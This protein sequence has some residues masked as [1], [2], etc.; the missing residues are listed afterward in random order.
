MYCICDFLCSALTAKGFASFYDAKIKTICQ[1]FTTSHNQV[2]SSPSLSHFCPLTPKDIQQ[3]IQTCNPTTCPWIQFLLHCLRPP[4]RTSCP[5]SRL[6]MASLALVWLHIL[7]RLS[8]SRYRE[9]TCW[10]IHQ[11]VIL[12][13]LSTAF[14]KVNHKTLLSTLEGL[15]I[16]R[17]IRQHGGYR[18]LLHA[19]YP[20]VSHNTC[21]PLQTLWFSL[22]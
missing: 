19:D 8:L 20:L 3:L 6:S 18:H 4:L 7:W 21:S 2:S 12:L 14:D 13:D 15:R 11:T 16:N 9:T 5:S 1:T 17:G 10:E 22:H